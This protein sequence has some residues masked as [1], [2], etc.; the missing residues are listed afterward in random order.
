MF[1]CGGIVRGGLSVGAL[2]NEGLHQ[3]VELGELIRFRF[4]EQHG[5]FIDRVRELNRGVGIPDKVGSLKA[6]DVP[7][8]ARAAMIE[9]A[10]DYP[11]PKSMSLGEAET[12][13]ARLQA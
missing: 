11:V 2:T 4:L 12:L 9:A 13:L 8:I 6:A 1:F 10:R 5:R 7:E 3:A